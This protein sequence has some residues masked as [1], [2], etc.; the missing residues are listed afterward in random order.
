MIKPSLPDNEEQR[1]QALQRY[2]IL[3]TAK[4]RSFED[5]VT[6]AT[7][8]CGTR[9]GAVTLVDRDRQWFKAR[10]ALDATE[11]SR[12]ISFCGHAILQPDQVM[13]VEDARQDPRFFD[14]PVVVDDPHIR[15]YAGAPLLSFDGLPLGTLCV[16]DANPGHLRPDQAQALAALSRQVSLV[17]ELRR[18]AFEIQQHMRDRAWYEQRLS[19]YNALLEQQ[20][21]DLAEQS[22]TD[23]LTGLPNRRA[24]S[25]A[26]EAAVIDAD[27]QPRQTAVALLDIDH[28]K[29]V[30]D[31]Y[32]HATGDH[33]LAEL[34]RLL[35][36]HFAGQGLAARYGGEEFV[37]LMPDTTLGTAELQCDFLR[38]AVADLPLGIPLTISIGVAAH[39]HGDAVEQTLARADAALYRAKHEGRNR[40]VRA[41]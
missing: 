35:R 4:E 36:A 19:E 28:F 24:M 39:R 23:P 20:N 1:L 9:M 30:N 12:D 8:L 33:V 22:R 10:Q 7:A 26:L 14:N 31:L 32:G 17:M 15:F 11:T 41:D 37:V 2:Q 18:Y 29:N 5:L 21:A 16:F 25:L 40:V 3:D 27:G 38:M 13:V 6:I 34:S